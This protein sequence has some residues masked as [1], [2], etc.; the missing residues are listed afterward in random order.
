[1]IAYS[2]FLWKETVSISPESKRHPI[3]KEADPRQLSTIEKEPIQEDKTAVTPYVYQC[4]E[5]MYFRDFLKP[6]EIYDPDIARDHNNRKADMGFNSPKE[7]A[8][9]AVRVKRAHKPSSANQVEVGS[10][11][12]TTRDEASDWKDESNIWYAY[13]QEIID[14]WRQGR[15]HQQLSVLWLYKPG[16]TVLSKGKYPWKN[17][18]FLSD[19]CNCGD[20]KLLASNALYMIDVEWFERNPDNSTPYFIRQKYCTQ[21]GACSFRDLQEADFICGCRN[22]KTAIH[23]VVEKYQIGDSV[24]VKKGK[25]LE[26]CIVIDFRMGCEDVLVRRLER[27]E[28][29]DPIARPNELRWTENISP[30][31]AS[32]IIRRCYI[33]VYKTEQVPSPYNRN[34]AGDCYYISA[35]TLSDGTCSEPFGK[36][37]HT[38]NRLPF[39]EGFDPL[40]PIETPLQILDLICGGGSL[41]RGVE[42]CGVGKIKCGIDIDI[43]AIHTWRANTKSNDAIAYWGSV[44]DCLVLAMA[45]SNKVN[46]L[47]IGAVDIILS[48]SPCPGFSLAQ[49]NKQSD[50]SKR[51]ASLVASVIA[52]IDFYRPRF[53]MIENVPGMAGD[54]D[55]QN[56]FAQVLCALVGMG[57]QTKHH[58]LDAWSHGDAQSRSRIFIVIAAPGLQLPESPAL[59]HSHPA[60]TRAVR[61]GTAVDGTPFGQ[62]QF[63]EAY[64]FGPVTARDAIGDLPD[65]EDSHVEVCVPFP[66]HRPSRTLSIPDR[67]C[68]AMIPTLPYGMDFTKALAKGVI[69]QPLFNTYKERKKY[70]PFAETNYWRRVNPNE[71]LST[72]TTWMSPW[73]FKTG[74]CL[75]W[76]Q[77]RLL[78]VMELRRA[79]GIPDDEVLIG[80]PAAQHKIA[81]NGVARKIAVA[82]GIPLREAWLGSMHN[83]RW[84]GVRGT[85]E[86]I[87]PNQLVAN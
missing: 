1:M 61:L 54:I 70:L 17:E 25:S 11:I 69:A 26:P 83:G 34:G 78:T 24:L 10:V 20:A 33:R 58:L 76:S 50:R 42:E 13:V 57:Y 68:A 84:S 40:E 12:A 74:R 63:E 16:D 85:R 53:G 3:W 59:T 43:Q 37:T 28:R 5:H 73:D 65:V 38:Q 8:N 72:V 2:N 35:Q 30:T 36:A 41:G 51:N 60:K 31:K 21:G 82:L 48:G 44:N 81:G 29:T 6:H 39:I 56:V 55:G 7:Q 86:T 22:Q 49:P 75:H 32:N 15:D 14:D 18:L 46:V 27:L 62:R 64:A 66:D 80:L 71:L 52:Y 87:V 23:E 9:S 19:N 45:G 67:C 77:H 79:Q 4:F 47:R